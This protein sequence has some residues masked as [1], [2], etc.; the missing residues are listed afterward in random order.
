MSSVGGLAVLR[1]CGIARPVAFVERE[2]VSQSL[3]RCQFSIA[4]QNTSY[5]AHQLWKAS[6]RA[7]CFSSRGWVRVKLG[8]RSDHRPVLESD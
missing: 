5:P 1:L 4:R 2:R 7:Q 8:F 3:P 6:T